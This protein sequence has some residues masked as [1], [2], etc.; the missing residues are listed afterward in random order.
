MKPA[1][2]PCLLAAPVNTGRPVAAVPLLILVAD[3]AMVAKLEMTPAGAGAAPAGA[4]AGV[5]AM[6]VAAVAVPGTRTTPAEEAVPLGVT[7]T[8]WG[9]VTAVLITLAVELPAMVT[10]AVSVHATVTVV[11]RET[12]V[13]GPA[14]A[15]TGEVATT[16]DVA[17]AAGEG[18]AVM[19]AGLPGM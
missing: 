13:D 12:T 4:G 6:V 18:A 3:A 17:D 8:T 7:K 14:P 11:K 2:A 19:R 9:T 1:A 15:A 5:A 16:P 10:P